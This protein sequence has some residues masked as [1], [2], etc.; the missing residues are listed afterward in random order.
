M[1]FQCLIRGTTW[2]LLPAAACC[3][4]AHD[5]AQKTRVGGLVRSTVLLQF[6]I[7]NNAVA[8]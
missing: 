4:A 1:A 6:G 7:I 5:D 3:R 2:L 8:E